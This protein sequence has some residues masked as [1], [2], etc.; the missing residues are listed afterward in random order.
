[1]GNRAPA[2]AP[3]ETALVAQRLRALR[4]APVDGISRRTLLRRSLG[5]GVGLWLAEVTAGSISF[6]WSVGRG[7]GGLVRVGTLDQI[8]AMGAGVPFL[9]G[10]PVYVLDP[11]GFVVLRYAPGFDASGLRTDLSRLLKVN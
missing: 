1:M 7:G 5:L 9:Q 11:N 2:I 3:E 4:E 6:L 8:A 10:F